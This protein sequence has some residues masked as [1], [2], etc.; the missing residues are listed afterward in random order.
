MRPQAPRPT[1]QKKA[2]KR[3]PQVGMVEGLNVARL[4]SEPL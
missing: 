2:E 4:Q 3:T 1:G